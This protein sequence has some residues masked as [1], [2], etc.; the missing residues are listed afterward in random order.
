[1]PLPSCK[2]PSQ[3]ALAVLLGISTSGS[4]FQRP[5]ATEVGDCSTVL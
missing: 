5:H 4:R 2:V 1:V 3:R